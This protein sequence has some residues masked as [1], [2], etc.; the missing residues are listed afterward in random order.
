MEAERETKQMSETKFGGKSQ[1]Q[2]PINQSIKR[3]IEPK[4]LKS[5][6][7]IQSINQSIDRTNE[8]QE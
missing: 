1:V 7:F 6:S 2:W 3:K 4:A 5:Y 8:R